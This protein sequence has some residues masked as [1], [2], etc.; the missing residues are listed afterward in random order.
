VKT[1]SLDVSLAGRTCLVTG[2]NSGIGR[3]AA[4]ALAGLGARVVMACRDRARGEAARQEI[5]SATRNQDVELR[6][7]DLA[8]QASIRTFAAEVA[9]AHPKL[10]VLVNNAGIWKTKRQQSSDGIELTWATN[11]LGYYLLT[12]LL[13]DT[14][15]ASA[16]ARV[17]NVA[18]DLARDLD[19]SDV[20]F[21]RRKYSGIRAYA[22]SK[23]ADRMLTWALARRLEGS[24]VSANALHPGGVNTGIFR[25][26]D[27]GVLARALLAL[28]PLFTRSPEQGADTCVWLA[29]SPQLEGVS[30]R[31][32]VDRQQR[33]CPYHDPRR[34]DEL[35]D[36]C[37]RMVTR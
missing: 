16:P 5:V 36:L 10:H 4:Q 14:L 2:A 13:L 35:W 29:A 7:V 12:D 11:V 17:V 37:A 31:Y 23:Q 8:S 18:S 20:E 22:Q 19:L 32:W 30:G 3:A 33:P 1:S 26:G 25:K 21:E 9:A 24:G 6:I 15:R 34:E 28:L 27:A